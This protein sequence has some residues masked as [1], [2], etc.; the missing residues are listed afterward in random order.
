MVE[1]GNEKAG[2]ID[3][4]GIEKRFTMIVPEAVTRFPVRYNLE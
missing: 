3:P 1:Q 2:Q 4:L